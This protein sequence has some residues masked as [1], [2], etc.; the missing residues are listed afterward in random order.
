MNLIYIYPIS[1]ETAN[2]YFRELNQC[3]AEDLKSMFDEIVNFLDGKT[4]KYAIDCSKTDYKPPVDLNV[5]CSRSE[6]RLYKADYISFIASFVADSRNLQPYVDALPKNLKS[7]LLAICYDDVLSLKSAREIAGDGATLVTKKKITANR[8]EYK[9]CIPWLEVH[10]LYTYRPTEDDVMLRFIGPFANDFMKCLVSASAQPVGVD[11]LP[12]GKLVYNGEDSFLTAFPVLQVLQKQKL[13]ETDEHFKAKVSVVRNI[14]KKTGLKDF[15]EAYKVDGV[16]ANPL[17]VFISLYVLIEKNEKSKK[18]RDETFYAKAAV[19]WIKKMQSYWSAVLFM[20]HLN[21]M[22]SSNFNYGSGSWDGFVTQFMSIVRESQNWLDFNQILTS[23][24]VYPLYPKMT[25]N[26][27][28]LGPFVYGVISY[29]R[30][31]LGHVFRSDGIANVTLPFVKTICACLAM[32]G[33]MEVAYD[34]KLSKTAVSPFD[35]ITH[36]RLTELG[37][38]AFGKVE[39]YQ[40]VRQQKQQTFELDDSRLIVRSLIPDNPYLD[41][42]SDIASYAGSQRYLLTCESFLKSCCSQKDVDDKIELFKQFIC[43]EPPAIW[44]DFFED[45]KRHS[46]PLKSPETAYTIF[47][48]DAEDKTLVSLICK[49]AELRKLCVRAENFLILVDSYNLKK[50]KDRLKILGYLV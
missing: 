25:I 27:A 9:S 30:K 3:L 22:R 17:S 41:L 33:V 4:I 50:F 35:A 12:Q 42:L 37:K 48:I 8:L 49:D 29:K 10:L 38:Y 46:N 45:I 28:E 24:K 16:Q 11:T 1:E 14:S 44:K 5:L 18:N 36:F 13:I 40:I 2:D 31:D 39:N 26:L 43:A 21:N 6:S 32:F 34:E 23:M 47:K 15:L 7:L 19:E 20:P